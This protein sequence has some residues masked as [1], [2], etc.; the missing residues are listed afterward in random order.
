MNKNL[1]Q[2]EQKQRVAEYAIDRLI[3]KGLL[4]S[5]MKLGM[6]TGSTVMPAINYLAKKNSSGI[7]SDIKIVPTSFQT[8]IACENLGFSVFSLNAKQIDASL[9]LAIDGADEIDIENKLVKGGGAALFLE[10]LIAYASKHFVIIADETKTVE[11]LAR[12]FPLPVEIVPESRLI[13]ERGLKALGAKVAIR[14]GLRKAGPVVTD[15]GN[16]ILD[17]LWDKESLFSASDYE[18]KINEIT[19]VVD[20]GFFTK[21]KALVFIAKADGSVETR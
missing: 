21:K 16:F 5:G 4:F 19:G 3:E 1:S 10:K 15:N 17:A 12:A 2:S 14:E 13:V 20:N 8:Q 18:T 6:G 9:D 11:S 7:L